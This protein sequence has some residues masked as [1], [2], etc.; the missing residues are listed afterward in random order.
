MKNIKKRIYKILRKPKV[1]RALKTFIEVFISYVAV[2]AMKVDVT[3]R[4]ALY[5]LIASA[6]GSAISVALNIRRVE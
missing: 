2:N 5:G 1:E 4:T 3:S 6:I